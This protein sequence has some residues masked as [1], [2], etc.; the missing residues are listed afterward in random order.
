MHFFMFSQICDVFQWLW[1]MIRF[2]YLIIFF[3][4]SRWMFWIG[5]ENLLWILHQC[6]WLELHLTNLDYGLMKVHRKSCYYLTLTL[7]CTFFSITQSVAHSSMTHEFDVL[8]FF[9]IIFIKAPFVFIRT[10][11]LINCFWKFGLI[12][13]GLVLSIVT[14]KDLFDFNMVFLVIQ[15][16]NCTFH[17]WESSI[18]FFL[19]SFGF[20]IQLSNENYMYICM[21]ERPVLS[22]D[23]TP[24]IWNKWN[25]EK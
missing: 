18:S 25:K 10:S 15:Y 2:I 11:K 12:W 23:M 22:Y 4:D 6:L 13:W 24:I 19:C 8:F 21:F 20:S 3:A 9:Q 16:L 17:F 1:F 14:N 5:D 7:N